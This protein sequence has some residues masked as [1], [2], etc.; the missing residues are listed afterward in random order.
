MERATRREKIIVIFESRHKYPLNKMLSFFNLAKSTY[1][2]T[3][4]IFDRDD[5]YKPIKDLITAIFNE[6][7]A[8]YGYRRITLEL[9]N[10]GLIF[11]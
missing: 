3:I 11:Y 1:F 4:K 5:K 10:R 6:N 9:K 7:K 8:R 2:Y